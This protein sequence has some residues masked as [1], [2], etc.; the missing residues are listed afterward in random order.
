ML[1]VGD[2]VY[3][4]L[5]AKIAELRQ[6]KSISQAVLASRAGLK[7]ATVASIEG[8]RQ[9]VTLEQLYQIA[10]ALQLRTLAEIIPLEV[11]SFERMPELPV[12]ELSFDQAVQIDGLLRS[13]LAGVRQARKRA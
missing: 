9:S 1:T 3:R 11:P 10:S 8:G 5:G 2:E 6:Q 7:R 13:A 12:S 4:A